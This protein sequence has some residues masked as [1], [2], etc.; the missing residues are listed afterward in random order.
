VIRRTKEDLEYPSHIH[1]ENVI[2]DFQN[3]YRF[4]NKEIIEK[5]LKSVKFK[6]ANWGLE[7]E[8]P[9]ASIS[10]MKL[11]SAVHSEEPH[12]QV[13]SDNNNLIFSFGSS[14]S[15][16]GEYVF[17]HNT[18]GT[19]STKK[20]YPVMQVQSI[21]SLSGNSIISI[22]DDGV[23]KISLDSGFANYEYILPSQ[24]K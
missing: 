16:A 4:I 18:D 10:R 11:M 24:T 5:N 1:F 14:V 12:F 19:L 7:F 8:P 15:H 23:M 6:G 17:K 20:T 3:D 22:S 9:V 21:L 13:W 2:G